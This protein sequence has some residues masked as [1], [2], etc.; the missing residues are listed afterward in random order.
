M[1]IAVIAITRNGALLG[2]KLRE[3]LA[4][5]ELYVSSRYAGRAGTD[6]VIF[7]S[8]DLKE[9]L[10]SLWSEVDGFVLIMATGIVVRMIAPLLESKQTDPA[11][12]SMDDA[13]RFAISLTSGHLGGANE[14]AERCAFVSGAR[15]VITTATDVNNLPSFDMLAREQGWVIDDISRIKT[16]NSLLLDGE[17]IAVVDP[18]G[19]TR[20]WFHG[21]GKLSFYETFAEAMDSR[22]R[23][24]L[25]VTNRHLPPQA[26]PDNLLILRPRNLVLG[27][28]CNRGTPV[29]EIDEFVTTHLKRIFVSLKSVRCIASAV[30]KQDETGLIAFAERYGIPL[31]FFESEELN[32]VACPSPP[33]EHAR[34]AIGAVGVAEPAAL[35]A[36]GGGRLMLQKVKSGNV[37]LAVAE[38]KADSH[39]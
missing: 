39:V 4:G 19:Q 21:C 2:K 31:E 37:T 23:G 24:F 16:L 9:L 27:I 34:A 33:S 35:L 26:L 20:C 18:G 8:G 38:M 30:A 6:R 15:A 36:S 5:A 13:G 10:A 11:V 12:V 1:R 14:L 3:S 25:F 7:E 29:D 32:R 22:A 28:G 17:E